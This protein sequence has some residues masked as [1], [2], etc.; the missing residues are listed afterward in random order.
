MGELKVPCRRTLP[1]NKRIS[2]FLPNPFQ[3][4]NHPAYNTDC[5]PV[6]I[7]AGRSHAEFGAA[8]AEGHRDYGDGPGFE[9]WWVS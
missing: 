1:E 3:F 6:L 8:N 7:W 4:T 2:M 5:G 9:S